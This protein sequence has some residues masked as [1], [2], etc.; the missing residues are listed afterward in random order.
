MYIAIDIGG[1]NLRV[2]ASKDG[3]DFFSIEKFKTPKKFE[4]GLAQ[5]VA[6][7]KRQRGAQ[8]IKAV[9]VAV[10]GPIDANRNALLNLPNLPGWRG[11]PLVKLLTRY[12]H[13]KILLINDADA[14]ALGEARQGAG[15]G[16]NRVGYL[17]LSTG[18]GGA[19]ILKCAERTVL[20]QQR[21]VL[22]AEPGHQ[23]MLP[24]GRKCGAGHPGCFEAYGSGTA[25]YKT[26]GVRPEDCKDKRIWARHAQII[27][28]GLINTIVHW[29]PDIVILG[30]GLTQAGALLFIPLRTYV[31]KHLKILKPP[32]IVPAKLG[33]NAGLYGALAFLHTT[34]K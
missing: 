4:H 9:V 14:A 28:W 26:Y 16:F 13:C 32:L 24:G 1:T 21:T 6:Y 12:L 17:T 29:S 20:N 19:L 22:S 33:D 10:P 34:I 27:G 8:K 11:K 7:A 5:I 31:R 15:R 3:S 25:F 2:A 30:G 18:I 23:I